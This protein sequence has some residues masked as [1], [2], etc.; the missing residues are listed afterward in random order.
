MAWRIQG[1]ERSGEFG[2]WVSKLTKDVQ[3]ITDP[4]DF[5]FKMDEMVSV[6]MSGT[7][8]MSGTTPVTVT[9][10]LGFVPVVFLSPALDPGSFTFANPETV[11]TATAS[12]NT[13]VFTCGSSAASGTISYLIIKRRAM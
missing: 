3:T 5:L 13:L 7:V 4:N 12:L 1:G 6:A 11:L 2:L 10:N 9:H 8:T